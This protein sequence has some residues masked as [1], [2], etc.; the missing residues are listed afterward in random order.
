CRFTVKKPGSWERRQGGRFANLVFPPDLQSRVRRLEEEARSL[1]EV[2]NI[3]NLIAAGVIV[4]EVYSKLISMPAEALGRPNTDPPTV[5]DHDNLTLYSFTVNT[6]RITLKLPPPADYAGGPLGFNVVWTNDGGVD[7]LNRRV[8]WELNYQAVSEDEVISGNHVN[9]PKLIDGLY[10]L[11]IGWVEQH[12]GF[13]EIAEADFLGKECIYV[14]LRAV[15]PLNPPLT[16]EPHLI[17]VCLRYNAL[18]I[19]A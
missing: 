5:V 8:R 2:I 14:R 13:M 9:S 1:L 18:R 16:C 4:G 6:D 15:T 3:T 19:P 10:D 12:T 17:G 11:S 7:D